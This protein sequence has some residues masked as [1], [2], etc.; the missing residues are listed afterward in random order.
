MIHQACFHLTQLLS[1]IS[2]FMLNVGAEEGQRYQLGGILISTNVP[3][4]T[5]AFTASKSDKA[6]VLFKLSN[7]VSQYTLQPVL[8]ANG[9]TMYTTTIL[10]SAEVHSVL[11]TSQLSSTECTSNQCQELN[12]QT[13]EGYQKT[14]ELLKKYNPDDAFFGD[15]QTYDP[16][17][18]YHSCVY[19][20]RVEKKCNNEEFC[21]PGMCCYKIA[22]ISPEPAN[23]KPV[24]QFSSPTLAALLTFDQTSLT[25]RPGQEE[26]VLV[27]NNKVYIT[28]KSITGQMNTNPIQEKWYIVESGTDQYRIGT[29][30][31]PGQPKLGTL[32]EV[33]T[34]SDGTLKYMP[35]M[36]AEEA[37]TL[38][39]SQALSNFQLLH[40]INSYNAE[41]KA[42]ES[43]QMSYQDFSTTTEPFNI[44]VS[45]ESDVKYEM[46]DA[47]A[48]GGLSA[49]L[50]FPLFAL[51]VLAH[52]HF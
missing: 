51:C 49:P 1:L 40:S 46:R 36:C 5:L 23:N 9:E 20:G 45:F 2:F 35:N 11:C 21:I 44:E 24:Y 15:N 34:S 10:N 42:G 28:V 37:N 38:A 29:G 4:Y 18:T 6:N 48:N 19:H 47:N 17:V 12:N 32:G 14:F 25:L 52:G 30:S 16:L 7:M 27:N 33:Q 50:L 43:V 8:Y 26:V 41:I 3:E 13:E 31:E 39:Q 22:R